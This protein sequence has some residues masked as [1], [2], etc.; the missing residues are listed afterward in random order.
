MNHRK[1][2]ETQKRRLGLTLMYSA[3][4]FV[5]FLATMLIVGIAMVVLIHHGVLVPGPVTPSVNHIIWG[6]AL[7]SIVIG[8][9]LSF[10]ASRIPLR[11]GVRPEIELL[12]FE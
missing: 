10:F 12:R 1:P 5:F 3:V 7:A 6:M 2:T 9:V 8:T 11:I 4:T